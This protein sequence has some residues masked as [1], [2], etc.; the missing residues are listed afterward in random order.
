MAY[1]LDRMAGV[2]LWMRNEPGQV[3]IPTLAGN[4]KPDFI[5]WLHDGRVLLLEIKGEYLWEPQQSDSWVR[6][7]DLKRWIPVV[8][9]V[10]GGD[11]LEFVVLLGAAVD[12]ATSVEE[13][14]VR[15][16]LASAGAQA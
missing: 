1:R 16:E 3:V 14:F 11:R 7:R 2:R 6:A 15:D 4:T 13:I 10:T 5:V 9:K 8:N 12:H